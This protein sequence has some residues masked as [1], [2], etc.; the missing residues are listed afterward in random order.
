MR[1][2][3]IE[4]IKKFTPPAKHPSP[5][6]TPI[7]AMVMAGVVGAT[8]FYADFARGNL[9]EELDKEYRVNDFEQVIN[10]TSLKEDFVEENWEYTVVAPS[11]QAFDKA[12]WRA[13]G[14]TQGTTTIV[15]GY[16]E[17]SAYDY[18]TASAVSPD[19]VQFGQHM[20]I[21]S[22]SG[23][24]LV[25]SRVADGVEGLRVNGLPVLAVRQA[26]NGVIYVIDEMITFPELQQQYSW[27]R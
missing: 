5:F 27:K 2:E 10:T 8:A 12:Q 17:L 20:R 18:V 25:F 7:V 24:D 16:S 19:D 1:R 3:T 14:D 21:P 9:S 26:E 4:E 6:A 23:T 22:I 11:D 13:S 15:P